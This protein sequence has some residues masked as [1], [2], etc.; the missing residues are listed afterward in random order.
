MYKKTKKQHDGRAGGETNL[1]KTVMED[2]KSPSQQYNLVVH[3][4]P[5]PG[6]KTLSS[7]ANWHYVRIQVHVFKSKNCIVCIPDYASIPP[8]WHKYKCFSSLK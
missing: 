3:P 1:K 7:L 4:G 6:G 8:T 2:S 5:N